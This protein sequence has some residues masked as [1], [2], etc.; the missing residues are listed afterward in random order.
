MLRA[1]YILSKFSEQENK[2]LENVLK[3]LDPLQKT[4]F[5]DFFN[6]IVVKDQYH[7]REFIKDG[8]TII[9]CGANIGIFSIFASYLNENGKIYAIEPVR[10]TTEVIKKFLGAFKVK[11][12][13]IIR[14][15]VGNKKEK[16]SMYLESGIKTSGSN[17]LIQGWVNY[18]TI[19][20]VEVNTIDNIVRENNMKS[21]DF[22]KMDIE[23]YE[24][25]AL[26]GALKTIR[27]FKPVIAVSAYHHRDDKILLPKIIK[28]AGVHYGVKFV[29][30]AEEDF[31][32]Y[33]SESYA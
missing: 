13:K 19:I 21:V 7:A 14:N 25:E 26:T 32:F 20:N 29:K 11:N 6:G 31:I 3:N 30:E 24:K 17:S 15:A 27:K 22:I 5:L 12:V 1:Q 9:D 23:G 28:M 18:D 2:I 4:T 33:P 8:Q 10:E 16:K